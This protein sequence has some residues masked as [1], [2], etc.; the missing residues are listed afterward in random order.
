MGDRSKE[1]GAK[2]QWQ[3]IAVTVIQQIRYGREGGREGG[4]CHQREGGGGGEEVVGHSLVIIHF[5]S[6]YH[7][8]RSAG[9]V[10]AMVDVSR[11]QLIPALHGHWRRQPIDP[12]EGPPDP[13]QQPEE[14]QHSLPEKN[15]CQL[16][17]GQCLA[18][19]AAVVKSMANGEELSL[20]HQQ[21]R[22]VTCCDCRV[23][24]SQ[25]EIAV[26]MQESSTLLLPQRSSQA[27][28][29]SPEGLHAPIV[30]ETEPV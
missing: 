5:G 21:P 8:I 20:R 4:S 30:T 7:W 3:P 10:G 9:Q 17:R 23:Q 19:A 15:R 13:H 26:L 12:S 24:R 14:P 11:A 25:P 28:F 16:E 27:V 6:L 29:A 22:S 18:H 2:R 1:P